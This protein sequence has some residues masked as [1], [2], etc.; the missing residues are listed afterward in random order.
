MSFNSGVEL[1]RGIRPADRLAKTLRL[2]EPADVSQGLDVRTSLIG[3]AGQQHYEVARAT[4]HALEI[5]RGSRLA[6]RH[7]KLSAGVGLTVRHRQAL[8]NACRAGLLPG[9]DRMKNLIPI[10]KVSVG[11]E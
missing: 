1:V 5:K 2:P 9:K 8:S 7:D 11:I 10:R 6:N 3:R 4:V